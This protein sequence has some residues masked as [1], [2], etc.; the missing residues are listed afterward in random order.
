MA[1]MICAITAVAVTKMTVSVTMHCWVW[2]EHPNRHGCKQQVKFVNAQ[3]Q[4]A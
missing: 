3:G 1:T 4:Q 2:D